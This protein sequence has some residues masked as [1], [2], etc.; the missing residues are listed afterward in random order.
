MH[1][2]ISALPSILPASLFAITVSIHERPN[3]HGLPEG[4]AAVM[5]MD[6]DAMDLVALKI[7]LATN[8]IEEKA[9]GAGSLEAW[10]RY[11][12]SAPMTTGYSRKG[13]PVPLTHTDKP[14]QP[15]LN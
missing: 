7:D 6:L 12:S 5:A 8:K 13:F 1:A 3:D 4:F 10:E 14:R 11:V 2:F 9:T 15:W